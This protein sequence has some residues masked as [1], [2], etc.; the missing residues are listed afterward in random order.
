MAQGLGI[1]VLSKYNKMPDKFLKENMKETFW[2]QKQMLK[3]ILVAG[4]GLEQP[5]TGCIF[6]K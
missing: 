4:T 3:R 1:F 2:D 5:V 6:K